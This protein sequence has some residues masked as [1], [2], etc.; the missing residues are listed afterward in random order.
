M[1]PHPHPGVIAIELPVRCCRDIDCDIQH[2]PAYRRCFWPRRL[3]RQAERT[4]QPTATWKLSESVQ[5]IPVLRHRWYL[6][7]QRCAGVQVVT[8]EP[9]SDEDRARDQLL[10]RAT[11]LR[12]SITRAQDRYGAVTDAVR[13]AKDIT[14]GMP[15]AQQVC[16][17]H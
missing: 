4:A 14:L 9:G 16:L 15:S 11:E 8:G 1:A 17:F 3:I 2:L 5:C 13:A 7:S 12:G 10:R 6:T